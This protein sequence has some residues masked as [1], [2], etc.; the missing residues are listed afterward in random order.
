MPWTDLAPMDQRLD[1]VTLA[2]GGE[3]N[4]TELSLRFGVSQKTAHKWIARYAR[5]GV[6]PLEDQSRSLKRSPQKTPNDIER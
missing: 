5:G 1:L 2:R 4:V 3:F 6:K